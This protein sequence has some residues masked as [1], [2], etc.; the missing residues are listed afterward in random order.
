MSVSVKAYASWCNRRAIA[1]ILVAL[2][3]AAPLAV[4]Q[5]HDDPEAI[6]RRELARMSASS[7][8]VEGK[9]HEVIQ[10][11]GQPPFQAAQPSQPRGRT[12]G[13][14]RV[15]GT[16][17]GERDFHWSWSRG[18]WHT[19]S[20]VELSP[21]VS[22]IQDERYDGRFVYGLHARHDGKGTSQ[23]SVDGYRGS[24][25]MPSLFAW[26]PEGMWATDFI[27][28]LT[29]DEVR[30]D[31]KRFGEPV[32]LYR[33]HSNRVR[34]ELAFSP[35]RGF[36]L[37]YQSYVGRDSATELRVTRWRSFGA[38][39]VPVRMEEISHSG[40]SLGAPVWRILRQTLTDVR[41]NTVGETEF[42]PDWPDGTQVVHVVDGKLYRYSG[43]RLQFLMELGPV[44]TS[45][46]LRA[47]GIIGGLIAVGR[48]L[49]AR[50]VRDR[51]RFR[52]A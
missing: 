30:F 34:A 21:G 8:S 23:G 29:T 13:I 41:V 25:P 4:A 49:M 38:C 50:T 45:R 17:P 7:F 9:V 3:G 33:G 16:V 36:G 42:R 18:R 20:M 46:R 5:R 39:H 52:P 31:T 40:P 1:G 14:T 10:M 37:V 11:V 2:L 51:R 19:R 48:V 12:S 47:W 22:M 6:L 35:S 15:W 44:T 32:L 26:T 43:G 27:R 28:Q 24:L